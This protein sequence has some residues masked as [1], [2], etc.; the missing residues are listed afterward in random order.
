M[1]HPIAAAALAVGFLDAKPATGHPLDFWRETLNRIPF[2]KILSMEHRP[3][4]IS[5]WPSE[6]TIWSATR[7]TPPFTP[8]PA[9]YGEVSGYYTTL[10][11]NEK[12]E[13]AWAQSVRDMEYEVIDNPIIPRRAM[14][15]RAGL[16][17]PGLF[18]PMI[19]PLHGSFVYIGTIMV[20]M[21]PPE[22][23]RGPEYDR[24]PGCEKCGNCAEACPTGAITSDGVDQ[25]KCLRKDM[26]YLDDIPE[27]HYSLMGR[28]IMGCDACQLVCPHNREV[29]AV[30]PSAEMIAPFGLEE[31]LVGPDVDAIA[32]RIT[33]HYTDRAKL[34]IQA[35]L[36][37]AN[38][39]RADLLPHIRKFLDSEE[40]TLR[41][42]AR[43]AVDK[44]G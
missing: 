35:V 21:I 25:T 26:N 28:R 3:E 32:A 5:G 44:L 15:I 12:R 38:T 6:T 18:G 16:G 20:R 37:A 27:E 14:A 17:V 10:N 29:A 30:T 22:G 41:R 13:N 24:S 36:A 8:W 42:V 23:T 31:L 33:S 9:R 34:R 19:T 1:S 4:Y 40:E 11:E 39:G 7:Q 2:G 43:W